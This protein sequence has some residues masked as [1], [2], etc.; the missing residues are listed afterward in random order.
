VFICQIR[1]IRVPRHFKN[2]KSLIL[3][4]KSVSSIITFLD[5][6]SGRAERPHFQITTFSNFQINSFSNFQIPPHFQ[7]IFHP[8]PRNANRYASK[9]HNDI[10]TQKKICTLKFSVIFAA[11]CMVETG[12]FF[13]H[14]TNSFTV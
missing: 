5:K 9:K 2:Q 1:F 12:L 3:V 11:Y 14:A 6:P 8:L 4:L 13:F 7:I 10:K